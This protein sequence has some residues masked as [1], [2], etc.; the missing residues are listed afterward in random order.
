M[1]TKTSV[2]FSPVVLLQNRNAVVQL[3]L[4]GRSHQLL[5]V[6]GVSQFHVQPQEGAIH[7]LTA[8]QALRSL[9]DRSEKISQETQVMTKRVSVLPP[10]HPQIRGLAHLIKP[11]LEVLAETRLNLGVEA[12]DFSWVQLAF[13]VPIGGGY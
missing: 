4:I 7:L 2:G 8:A 11:R 10:E 1:K 9:L 12:D 3:T 6:L 5:Q 13:A